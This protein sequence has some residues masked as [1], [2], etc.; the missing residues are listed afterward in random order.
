MPRVYPRPLRPNALL[1]GSRWWKC[2]ARTQRSYPQR[3]HRPPASATRMRL[4]L[5]RLRTTASARQARQRYRPLPSSWNSV[6]PWRRQVIDRYRTPPPPP[7]RDS[8][9]PRA[10]AVRR[11]W[12]ERCSRTVVRLTPKCPASSP[13]VASPATRRLSSSTSIGRGAY[14]SRPTGSSSSRRAILPTVERSIPL[15]RPI[16]AS[17]SPCASRALN[18]ARSIPRSIA[19]RPDGKANTCSPAKAPPPS[20]P[21]APR[22][23]TA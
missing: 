5:R 20:P 2:S 22:A 6:T 16:S 4:T 23:P 12:R 14:F 10:R 8:R 21:G 1:E 19:S 17:E 9:R 13:T 15:R 18:S 3:T 7:R 11:A